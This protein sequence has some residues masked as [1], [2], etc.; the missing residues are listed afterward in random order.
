MTH[1]LWYNLI[2]IPLVQLEA[3]NLNYKNLIVTTILE[4]IHLFPELLIS[5]IVYQ[6]TLWRLTLLMHLR[7][8][9]INTRLIKMLFM[10][11]NQIKKEPEVYLFV[12]NI[13][14]FEMP[15][16]RNSCASNIMLDWIGLCMLYYLYKNNLLNDSSQ[17]D[18][19]V[20]LICWYF[21]K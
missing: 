9:L 2:F 1:V 21:L 20:L 13:M 12:L 4:N 14:L 15:A 18:D 10:T 7:I 3:I 11:T 17:Q 6:I 8:I 19:H 5:G 16:E